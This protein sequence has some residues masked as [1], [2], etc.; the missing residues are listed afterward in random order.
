MLK[1]NQVQANI[2][3]NEV[4]YVQGFNSGY[5]YLGDQVYQSLVN[6]EGHNFCLVII[7]TVSI[8]ER[9]RVVF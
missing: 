8:R 4:Q 3:R 5:F 6:R 1:P 9:V 7:I 2:D